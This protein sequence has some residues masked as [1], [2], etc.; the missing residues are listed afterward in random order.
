MNNNFDINKFYFLL[1][2]IF[3]WIWS[4]MSI[5]CQAGVLCSDACLGDWILLPKT[6]YLFQF[7]QI[8]S[9]PSWNCVSL[10]RDWKGEGFDGSVGQRTY[11]LCHYTEPCLVYYKEQNPYRSKYILSVE[12]IVKC[13]HNAY[14]WPNVSCAFALIY[15]LWESHNNCQIWFSIFVL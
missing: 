5:Q 12:E 10:P 3:S 4:K 13:R 6:S 2:L 9:I 7:S 14:V 8:S 1:Q 15:F 11:F